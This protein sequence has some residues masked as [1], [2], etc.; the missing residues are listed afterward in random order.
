M[1]DTNKLLLLWY[2]LYVE[3]ST[4][5]ESQVLNSC[6]SIELVVHFAELFIPNNQ[7]TSFIAPNVGDL[8]YLLSSSYSF[9]PIINWGTIIKTHHV[10]IFCLVFMVTEMLM[11]VGLPLLLLIAILTFSLS[12]L[13]GTNIFC[14]L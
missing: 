12:F 10:I 8:Q 14:F 5:S 13:F 3:L 7:T 9:L 6:C 11:T 2:C 4:R 1:C